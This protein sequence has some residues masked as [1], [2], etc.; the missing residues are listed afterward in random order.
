MDRKKKIMDALYPLGNLGAW[1]YI[2]SLRLYIKWRNRG[3]DRAATIRKYKKLYNQAPNLDNPITLNE[4]ILWLKLHDHTPLH[5][6]CADKF[7]VRSYLSRKFGEDCLI[8]LIYVTD[9]YK[10]IDNKT[11]PDEPC[12]IK[13]SHSQGDMLIVRDKNSVDLKKLHYLMKIWLHRNLYDET[14]EWQY[15]NCKPRIIIEKLLQD[16]EG[17]IPNDY[18]LHFI[19][20]KLEFVYC[21]VGRETVNK[22]NIYDADWNPLYFSWVEP[23]KDASNI[24]GEEIPAP[25]SFEEMKRI[26]SEIAKDFP[27]Y[28]RVDFYDVNGK[29]Y[30]G[31]ITF[32]HGS[33]FD[34]FVPAH[35]DEDYGKRMIL[36]ISR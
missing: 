12:I 35:Y 32:H 34:I 8:P 2:I 31:E 24:R 36:P 10:T 22:R 33:G 21:S 29:L 25:E 28:V 19:N 18:K 3:G 15:K 16:N 9:D 26:G 17:H 7:T 1:I 14:Q 30:F 11:I 6:Q 20:G 13:A 5:T 4:K 23:F 27:C